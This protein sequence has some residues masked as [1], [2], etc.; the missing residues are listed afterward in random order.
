[1][2]VYSASNLMASDGRAVGCS[3]YKF[4]SAIPDSIM[5]RHHE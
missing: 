3:A 2:E 4:V 1:M 5:S